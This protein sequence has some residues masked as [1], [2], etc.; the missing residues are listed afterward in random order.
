MDI[1]YVALLDVLGFSDLV[2]LDRTGERMSQ[3]LD[4]IT[5]TTRESGVKSVVFS[6]SIVL[7]S[8]GDD[9]H[10]LLDLI[11]ASSQLLGR[12]LLADIPLRGAIAFGNVFRRSMEDSVFIAGRA[13]VDAY[14]F[15]QLQDWVGIIV[16][17]SVLAS[18]P[19]LPNRCVIQYSSL[20]AIKKSLAWAAYV[21]PYNE[22]PFHVAAQSENYSGY[23]IVPTC[24]REIEAATIRSDF[25]PFTRRL[26]WLTLLAPSPQTQRK[27][28]RANNW[29]ITQIEPQ[30]RQIEYRIATGK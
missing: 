11:R 20:E 23:A 5:Q 14:K 28:Q 19:D 24:K 25:M 18:F 22:I 2:M 9:E 16:A 13:I 7:T 15:E 21:Q 12:C 6:D 4:L 8:S 29:L 1:G 27:Y 3:Y 30:W 10:A 17:P 26:E